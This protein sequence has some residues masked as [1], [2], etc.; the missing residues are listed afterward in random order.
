MIMV[1]LSQVMIR[2]RAFITCWGARR[3]T[4]IGLG[5]RARCEVL[6]TTGMGLRVCRGLGR[7]SERLGPGWK[8]R[9]RSS[10]RWL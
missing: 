3:G 6:G 2:W 7:S 4:M 5:S 9:S 10:S 1:G 8:S